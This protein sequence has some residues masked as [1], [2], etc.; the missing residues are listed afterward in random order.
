MLQ[1]SN[2]NK[3]YGNCIALSDFNLTIEKGE[4]F[5]FVGPNGAGKTTSMK[6]IAGLLAADSGTIE[7]DGVNI[8]KNRKVMKYKIGYMPDFFGVYDNLKVKEYMDFYA[9]IYGIMGHQANTLCDELLDKVDLLEAR[10]QYVDELSRG[11]K[12]RLCLAR[13]LIHKPSLLILDEPASGLDPRARIEM[14]NILKNLQSNDMTVLI[15]SHILP[16]LSE[17][18]S[19]IGIIEQGSMVAKGSVEEIKAMITN[20]NLLCIQFTEVGQEVIRLLEN[21]VLI[22]NLK[23]QGNTASMLFQGEDK[24]EASLLTNLIVSGA[25]ICSFRREEGNLEQLF[26]QITKGGSEV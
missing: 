26:L 9:S 4:I 25:R 13:C 21:H 16:E 11:M 20:S 12:Q 2:L 3:R 23:I 22:T 18:C 1:I 19:S 15:S 5:G 24:E 7:I 17:I 8:L 14:K 6:I 10:E